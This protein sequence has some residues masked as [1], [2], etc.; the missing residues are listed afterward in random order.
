MDINRLANLRQAYEALEGR[1]QRALNTQVG[2]VER[3]AEVQEEVLS[4]IQA[5]EQVSRVHM[6]LRQTRTA[7][8]SG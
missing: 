3:L 2:D 6:P 5:V 8:I 1:V 7:M 4:Y